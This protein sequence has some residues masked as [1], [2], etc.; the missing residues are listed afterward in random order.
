MPKQRPQGSLQIAL[1]A[2]HAPAA[3]PLSAGPA[4]AVLAALLAAGAFAVP[5][6]PDAVLAP[7]RLPLTADN[8]ALVPSP[9][10]GIERALPAA[11][12]CSPG[13][14]AQAVQRLP[15]AEKARLRRSALCLSRH[16]VPGHVA[17]LILARCV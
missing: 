10:P 3:R 7:G 12:A 9:C 1:L 11:L 15:P 16:G 6:F 17:A 8:W 2:N 5:L 4:A 13:Q 14:A